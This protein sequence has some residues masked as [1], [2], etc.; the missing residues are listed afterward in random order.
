MARRHSGPHCHRLTPPCASSIFKL[1]QWRWACSAVLAQSTLAHALQNLLHQILKRWPP[2]GHPRTTVDHHRAGGR[3]HPSIHAAGGAAR[4][5][6]SKLS[7]LGAMH[8]FAL[9]CIAPS[10][11]LFGPKRPQALG[12][13]V[14]ACAR[15][16]PNYVRT[17]RSKTFGPR[18]LRVSEGPPGCRVED[19]TGLKT[20]AFGQPLPVV[21]RTAQRFPLP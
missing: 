8:Y 10:R 13:R 1:A 6:F 17:C 16:G 7:V 3:C 15:R 4:A 11:G 2:R 9:E 12:L 18:T 5:L 21:R 19:P 20:L 14:W